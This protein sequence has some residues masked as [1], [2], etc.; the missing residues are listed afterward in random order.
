[1]SPRTLHRHWSR[2][3]EA[4][5][6]RIAELY[7]ACRASG[8]VESIH[9][10]RVA[11]RRARLYAHVG[12]PLLRKKSVRQFN[13]WAQLIN[14]WL[15]PIRDCDVCL[16]WLASYADSLEM[17]QAVHERRAGLWQQAFQALHS[18]QRARPVVLQ[19]RNHHKEHLREL[20][21]R[22]EQL[23]C[24][25]TASVVD[26]ISRADAMDPADLHRLRRHLRRWRYLRELGLSAQAQRTDAGLAWL[27][28]V[29]DVLGESQNLQ[30]TMELLSELL[31]PA[32]QAKSI[33]RAR[34]GQLRWIGKARRLL[35]RLPKQL[36]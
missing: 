4:L 13:A 15:G 30:M 23:S 6:S 28:Q 10:L 11:I 21:G 22:F 36:V 8:G 20:E 35:K 34:A 32:K 2:R 25:V 17:I 29:Q 31:T 7:G 12:R 19:F 18:K 5:Q 33:R 26:G 27:N 14:G 16:N 3:L 1:M 24:R 9:D